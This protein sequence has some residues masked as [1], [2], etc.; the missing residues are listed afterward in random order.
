MPFFT[1]GMNTKPIIIGAVVVVVIAVILG[2]TFKGSGASSDAYRG[3]TYTIEG[4]QV[5]LVDGVAETEAAPGSASK[6]VTKIF[7]NEVKT[8]F[9]EDGRGDVAFI[10]T[11]E[12]GGSGTFYYLVG[13]IKNAEGQTE[14]YWGMQAVLLGDRIAPQTTEYKNKEIIV[15]FATRNPGEDFSVQPSLNVSK[16]FQ[17][18]EGSLVQ[19]PL[20]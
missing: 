7:G 14:P 15:N 20:R 18:V 13:A 5:T 3:A 12:A 4:K 6:V 2:M 19:A 1:N 9:N 8:D 10:M 11:Q 17:F 16:T